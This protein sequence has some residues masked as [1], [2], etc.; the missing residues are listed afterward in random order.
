MAPTMFHIV[1]NGMFASQV[2]GLAINAWSV[3]VFIS[4][5]FGDVDS[6]ILDPHKRYMA[7]RIIPAPSN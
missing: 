2:G 4:A 1:I 3:K 7:Y 5:S 6:R